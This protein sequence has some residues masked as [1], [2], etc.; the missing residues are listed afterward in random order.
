MVAELLRLN[1]RLTANS[2]SRS[3]RRIARA[4]VE[5]LV[6][7]A[8]VAALIVGAVLLGGMDQAF[9]RRIV[10]VAGS[11]V[12]VAAFAVP[13]FAARVEPLDRRALR[14]YGFRPWRV[15]LTLV[16][17]SFVGPA[18]LFIVPLGFLPLLVWGE[19]A[20]VPR[21]LGIGALLALQ[22]VISWRLGRAVGSILNPRPRAR[23]VVRLLL[24]AA[25]TAALALLTLTLLPRAITRVPAAQLD[26]ALRLLSQTGESGFGSIIDTLAVTP[27]GA[28]WAATIPAQ[29]GI[30]SVWGRA[31][32][33]GVVT[34]VVLALIWHV[35]V[36][37]AFRATWRT[38]AVRRRGVPGWFRGFPATPIGAATARSL[39]YWV[40]DP[41]YRTVLVFLPVIPIVVLLAFWISGMPL[42]WGVLI[43]LPLMLLLVGWSTLH[44]DVAYDSTAVWTLLAAQLR[45]RADRIGR[46]VPVLVIGA[47]LLAIGTPLTVWAY[48]DAEVAPIV[49]GV[50]VA[51]LLGAVGVSSA[52]SARSPY[53]APRPGD[54]SFQQPELVGRTGAS[55]QV[56]SFLLS[57]LAASPAVA[58]AVVWLL[59]VPGPWNW[60]SLIV[61]AVVGVA[62]LGAGISVGG[63][64]FDEAGPELLAFTM[65]N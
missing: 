6:I 26:A 59:E 23:L 46:A 29:L 37:A 60:V 19:L 65:R 55:A 9:A 58:F 2:L 4:V 28:L 24:V 10:I 11:I 31:V 7:L 22:L 25:A 13:A 8:A 64:A 32:P 43:P 38:R 27:I 47:A 48:G 3:P 15:S 44:N 56:G 33:I 42:Q 57:L 39:T 17:I 41:R 52:E 12:S 36:R 62:V 40:R 63:R 20:S 35:V 30:P 18:A 16:L 14:G 51:T 54:A 5:T 49:L 50:G 61:G 34:I 1:L 45:G 21:V 53:P